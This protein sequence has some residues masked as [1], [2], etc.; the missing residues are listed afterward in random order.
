MTFNIN[1]GAELA[2]V[3]NK[4]YPTSLTRI[5]RLMNGKCNSLQGLSFKRLP[6]PYDDLSETKGDSAES[7]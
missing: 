1:S 3:L 6:D 4:A 2:R 5:D 7:S